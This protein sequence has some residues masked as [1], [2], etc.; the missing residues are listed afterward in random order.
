M[1]AGPLARA[2]IHEAEALR[3]T[4]YLDI[5]GVWTI[6]W[7]T[8]RYPGGRPVQPGET[9]T[10]EQADEFFQHDLQRFERAVER[11]VT[12]PITPRQ[13]GALVSFTYNV[14]EGALARSNLLKR[15]NANPADP[16]IRAEFMKWHRAGGARS[17]GLWRRRHR[18]ADFYMGTSTPTPPMPSE[19]VP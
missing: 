5:A 6:G 17:R 18:E 16:A 8:T 2:M 15:V 1:K 12:T 7:G 9:C 11:L 4:A 10:P 19:E 14:G 3:L 13:F